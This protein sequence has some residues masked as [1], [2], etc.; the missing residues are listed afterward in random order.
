MVSLVVQLRNHL[1][2]KLNR[3]H[4][5]FAKILDARQDR[6]VAFSTLNDDS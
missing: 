4:P 2:S 1:L 6:G 5:T 3:E